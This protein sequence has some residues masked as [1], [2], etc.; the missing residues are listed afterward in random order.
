MPAPSIASVPLPLRGAHLSRSFLPVALPRGP[1]FPF[2]QPMFRP[3][4]TGVK[5]WRRNSDSCPGWSAEATRL[6]FPAHAHRRDPQE[7][8][9]VLLVRV[10]PPEDRRGPAQPRAGAVRAEEGQPRLRLG[11]LRRGGL[12]ARAHGRGDEVDQGGPRPRGDGPP[13]LRRR[14]GRAAARDPRRG[15]RRRGRQRAGAARRPA[16]GRGGLDP[17]SGWARVLGRPDRADPGQVRLLHRRHLLPRG[18]SGGARPRS[19]P[20]LPEAQGGCRRDLPDHPA[21]LRERG[22]L[23]VRRERARGRHRRADHRRASCRSRTSSRSSAS[24]R[25]AARPSRPPCTS[26]SRHGTRRATRPS[27][28]SASPTPRFS[29]RIC[30]SAA[31]PASTSTRS[32]SRRRRARSCPRSRRGGRGSAAPASAPA[33]ARQAS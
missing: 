22:L 19:R 27:R 23:P 9:P 20:A 14:A 2:R 21:L 16:Q 30:S 26:S 12:H 1:E 13:V 17:S 32:T 8:G 4:C 25:C 24:R 11:H 18:A 28:S 33:P 5:S 7:S 31:R 3:R 29:V 6:P 10:L 15:G